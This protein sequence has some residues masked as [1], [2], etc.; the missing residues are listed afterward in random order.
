MKIHKNVP[1]GFP[2]GNYEIQGCKEY[3]EGIEGGYNEE[4]ADFFTVYAHTDCNEYA[5]KNGPA[6]AMEDFPNLHEAL[7]YAHKEA[8][9]RGVEVHC[10]A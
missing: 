2:L 4:D 9:L 10:Y 5:R 6:V 3:P 8:Q 1:D 7:T